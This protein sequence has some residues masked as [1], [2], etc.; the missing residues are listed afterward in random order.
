MSDLTIIHTLLK[1]VRDEQRILTKTVPTL[2]TK[3]ELKKLDTD[4]TKLKTGVGV[5]LTIGGL[6][7]GGANFI[8][9]IFK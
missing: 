4:I 1:E 9:G 8:L 5:V 3:E 2:A 7:M 6:F